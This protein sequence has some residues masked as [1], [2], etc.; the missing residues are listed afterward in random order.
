MNHKSTCLNIDKYLHN[1]GLEGILRYN[2]E[3]RK[4]RKRLLGPDTLKLTMS[5]LTR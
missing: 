1:S 2:A 5:Q 4:Q 3:E